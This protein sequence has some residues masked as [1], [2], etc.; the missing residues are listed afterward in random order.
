MAH[1]R[2]PFSKKSNPTS[3]AGTGP[4]HDDRTELPQPQR[5]I[6]EPTPNTIH[7]LLGKI[8]SG[9]STDDR[10]SSSPP[11]RSSTPHLKLTTEHATPKAASLMVP[12]PIRVPA[13]PGVFLPN[14]STESLSKLS[15]GPTH[16]LD[17]LTEGWDAVRDGA[18]DSN[19]NRHRSS[20]AF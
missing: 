9:P 13:G 1:F 10:L 3:P 16:A 12:V 4:P 11:T 19:L 5:H 14:S 17:N 18:S 7:R 15:S 2:N 20:G 6:I 8:I